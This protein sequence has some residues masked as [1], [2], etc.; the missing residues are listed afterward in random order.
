MRSEE[1]LLYPEAFDEALLLRYVAGQTTECEDRKVEEW[2][3]GSMENEKVFSEVAGLYHAHRTRQNIDSR[4]SRSA[5]LEVW[6]R[7]RKGLWR[8]RL[9]RMAVA[10]SLV[11]GA[12]GAAVI[13]YGSGSGEVA[14]SMITVQS[15]DNSRT[16]IELPDG[17][18]VHLN[19]GSVITYPSHYTGGGRE[20]ILSG[21]AYF[22]VFRDEDKPF[23][24]TTPDRKY[25]VRVLGTE[26]NMQ[27]YE[28]DGVIQTSLVAGSVEI[29]IDIDDRSEGVV[30]LPSQKAIY[31][32]DTHRLLV[33]TTNIDR[34]TDWMYGRL[35][36]RKTPMPEVL[37]RL[38][39][40]YDVEFD[41]KNPVIM[42]YTFTGT[43]EEKPLFQVLDYM[44]ISSGIENATTYSSDANGTKSVVILRR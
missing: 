23:V 43:F 12:A 29:D 38:S 18:Q 10:A 5:L 17:T 19:S 37:A 4:D 7:I 16:R 21:E 40:F 34:E 28:D 15:N 1:K 41:V 33:T 30:L 13:L 39:R 20:V 27:A 31:H 11:I 2:V 42:T 3:S 6:G 14:P 26:F 36:F 8:K 22:K 9:R 24:V 32:T 44:K 25:S 35:V